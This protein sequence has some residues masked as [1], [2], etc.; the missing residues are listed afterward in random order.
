M[1]N[2]VKS[3]K[4]DYKNISAYTKGVKSKL[5]EL[6]PDRNNHYVL[7]LKMEQL[8]RDNYRLT[9]NNGILTLMMFK[10][11]DFEKPLY[12]HHINLSEMSE[13]SYDEVVD[14]EDFR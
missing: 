5:I 12:S 1:K 3:I 14:I 6:I 2:I 8:K 11:V 7:F 13:Y 10:S 9:L 4:G